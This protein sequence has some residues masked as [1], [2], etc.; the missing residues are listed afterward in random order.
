MGRSTFHMLLNDDARRLRQKAG[1]DTPVPAVPTAPAEPEASLRQ[2]FAQAQ[3]TG[4]DLLIYSR[5]MR[6]PRFDEAFMMPGISPWAE[7][8][9]IRIRDD[10]VP[11][12]S[13]RHLIDSGGPISAVYDLK[14]PFDQA[15]GGVELLP[16]SIKQAIREYRYD[17]VFPEL[18]FWQ[19][20]VH[21]CDSKR[22]AA[23]IKA[24][25]IMA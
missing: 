7:E 10:R 18:S 8:T 16:D 13:L 14:K 3:Q 2:Q 19:R 20:I 1:T 5:V 11:T 17:K 21:T 4:A 25:P 24:L 12:Q 15:R 22:R 9:L 6:F 23:F